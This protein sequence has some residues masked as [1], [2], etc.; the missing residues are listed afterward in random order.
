MTIL[1]SH[2]NSR[3]RLIARVLAALLAAVAV[4]TIV[5][6]VRPHRGKS[7]QHMAE[8]QYQS[9]LALAPDRGALYD[10]RGEP[11]AMSMKTP[12]LA[13]NPRQ[14][15][16]LP[17]QI[18]Q[19]AKILQ[20]PSAKIRDLAAKKSHFA[21]L[22]RQLEPQTAAAVTDMDMPGVHLLWE[23]GR[24][25]P[26]GRLAAP[27]LGF[28]GV[29][30]QGLAG[31][32][33]AYD[34]H[35]RGSS[36]PILARRDAR[37]RHVFLDADTAEPAKPGH[38]IFLTIDRAI[39]EITEEALASGL[40]ESRA[41]RGLAIVLDPHSG[42]ILASASQPSFDPN[43]PVTDLAAAMHLGTHWRFEPGSTSKPFVL[44]QALDLGITQLEEVHDCES[45]GRLA[46]GNQVIHDERPLGML[47]TPSILIH[48]S[49]IG[50]VRL[51]RRLGQDRLYETLLAFGFAP[52]QPLLG[53]PGEVR[54]SLAHPRKWHPIQFANISFGQGFGTN[55]LEMARA[56]A[57]IANG[58]FSLTPRLV[59]RIATP[60]GRTT[61]EAPTQVLTPVIKPQ[62]AAI[63]RQ[64]MADVVERGTGSR[65][66]SLLYTTAGK[67]GTAEK[68][69]PL[70]R[71]YSL[72]KRIANF[73]GFA[74]ARNPHIVVY[75][76]LDE[77]AEKPYYGGR[78]AAP[79][80][81]EIA[82]RT[83]KYLNVAPDRDSSWVLHRAADPALSSSS[84]PTDHR[85]LG[86]G[87][88]T[89]GRPSS[90]PG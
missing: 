63:M 81:A 79:V 39:Q 42:R 22:K 9:T 65:A 73:G 29:D 62:T 53:L 85:D 8:N 60:D 40:R 89:P 14:F 48:S 87:R 11:L 68:I 66:R 36:R 69:D 74:P 88:P 23:P 5:L 72:D 76:A 43:Q 83:L 3:P 16:P 86:R 75:V 59:E 26:S 24:F 55:G 84:Q 61:V 58:G 21:W 38:N 30:H 41:A 33:K 6:H 35:L 90:P 17:H 34:H 47:K 80:F 13:I 12:S 77:P 32:E 49:N 45:T 25:Y 51:A 57:V 10:Q 78:W 37:G 1:P 28:V 31:L 67:T 7:L 19:L 50:I 4:R 18:Q 15:Q 54:G 2:A 44:A 82:E 71:S 20:L 46:I 52:D 27:L 70:T 56:F 64:I